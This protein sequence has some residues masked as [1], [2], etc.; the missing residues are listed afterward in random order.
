MAKS[1]LTV[2][3]S[4]IEQIIL[5]TWATSSD[6]D[7]W[8]T[9]I[10]VQTSAIRG[11]RLDDTY[12]Q[13][14]LD[15]TIMLATKSEHWYRDVPLDDLMRHKQLLYRNVYSDVYSVP[16]TAYILKLGPY[17]PVSRELLTY[18][19]RMDIE[20]AYEEP[21]HFNHLDAGSH[22][23]QAQYACAYHQSPTQK[24]HLLR[25]LGFKRLANCPDYT[26]TLTVLENQFVPEA[27]QCV[28]W[29]YETNDNMNHPE[30]SSMRLSDC[31]IFSD[32]SKQYDLYQQIQQSHLQL[33]ELGL[34]PKVINEGSYHLTKSLHILYAATEHTYSYPDSE[35]FPEFYRQLMLCTTNI[36]TDFLSQGTYTGSDMVKW[37][38]Q[39][40]Q[41]FVYYGRDRIDSSNK[42]ELSYGVD[43]VTYICGR[44]RDSVLKIMFDAETF[45][46]EQSLCRILLEKLDTQ[47]KQKVMVPYAAY[48]SSCETLP[49]FVY[50]SA[51]K[52][53][54]SRRNMCC[55]LQMPY[56]KQSSQL[57]KVYA[58]NNTIDLNV[59]LQI[60]VIQ[61]QLMV[62]STLCHY[63][64]HFGNIMHRPIP[65]KITESFRLF[66]KTWTYDIV[67]GQI[68]FID[69]SIMM[70]C[71]P[72][73][74]CMAFHL[75]TSIGEVFTKSQCPISIDKQE[76]ET[77][78]MYIERL[79]TEF[80]AKTS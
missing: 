74:D 7:T 30:T 50:D 69:F 49:F 45:I 55:F 60:L 18:T 56:F 9:S 68:A 21:Y 3:P 41:P 70:V 16:N 44:N 76:D 34:V 24:S 78:Q 57:M 29:V 14:Y 6:S 17:G 13:D 53:T 77:S 23:R 73:A 22:A 8:E 62:Q 31:H 61:L 40:M 59:Y 26:R 65:R 39:P 63:D 46:R 48:M 71:G 75:R 36:N 12:R 54:N 20:D 2:E 58:Q 67:H 27:Q 19:L 79:L 66:D 32:S 80:G 25:P 43:G 64:L 5:Q 15:D 38:P 47:T 10:Q 72:T 51:Y 37:S 42:S 1:L 28:V 35:D 11:P 4:E 52:R 33:I